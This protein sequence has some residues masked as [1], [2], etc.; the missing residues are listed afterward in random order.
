LEFQ[1]IDLLRKDD[2]ERN[3]RSLKRKTR[4]KRTKEK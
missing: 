3:V 2:G 1:K 4:K